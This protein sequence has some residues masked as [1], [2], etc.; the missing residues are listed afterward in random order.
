MKAPATATPN[1]E[2]DQTR[3]L[4]T[5]TVAGVGSVNS[6]RP[7]SAVVQIRTAPQKGASGATREREPSSPFYRSTHPSNQLAAR[8]PHGRDCPDRCSQCLGAPV[9]H[10]VIDEQRHVM[11]IDGK[12]VRDAA[13]PTLVT[14]YPT[15]KRKG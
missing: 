8:K 7:K 14:A 9:R 6:E 15:R 11:L 10:V 3:G 5:R 12:V 2:S 1:I 4:R 13:T